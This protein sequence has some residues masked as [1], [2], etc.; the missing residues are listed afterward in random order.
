MQEV[1]SVPEV[2][3]MKPS[4]VDLVIGAV[5]FEREALQRRP[6]EVLPTGLGLSVEC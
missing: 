2:N 4:K 6:R 5:G 1:N 3:S